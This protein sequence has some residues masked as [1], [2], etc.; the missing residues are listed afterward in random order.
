MLT[1]HQW[2]PVTSISISQDMPQPWITKVQWHSSECNFTLRC[3]SHQ[4]L[5]L[6]WKL[7]KFLFKSPRGQWVNSRWPGDATTIL[8]NTG[9]SKEPCHKTTEIIDSGNTPTSCNKH[10]FKD[11]KFQK[12]CHIPRVHPLSARDPCVSWSYLVSAVTWF[13][14]TKLSPSSNITKQPHKTKGELHGKLT[15]LPLDKMAAI[16][17]R[18]FSDA[19]LW[20]KSFVF[21]LKFHWSFFLRVQLTI[22]LHWFR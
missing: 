13:T 12:A 22:F 8:L 21:W 20:M 15:H 4:S 1:D 17:Q 6:A 19:F 3:L 5:K 18:I 16:S 10:G 2:S 9:S 11:F 14:S 7:S